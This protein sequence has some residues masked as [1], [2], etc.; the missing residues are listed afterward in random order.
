MP[1]NTTMVSTAIDSI[2]LKLS[3]LT[4][5]WKAPN[6][7]PATPPKVAPSAKASSFMLRVLMPIALAAS[8]SSRIAAHAR[9]MRE[10]CR[11]WMKRMEPATAIRKK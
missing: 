7:A 4:K 8:S 6:K 3:G 10:I 5:P 2:R 11:R 1:P 9:P